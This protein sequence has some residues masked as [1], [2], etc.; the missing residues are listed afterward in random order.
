M[1]VFKLLAPL[2]LF[3]CALSAIPLR[4][5]DPVL[6]EHFQQGKVLWATQ[7]DRDGASAKFEQVLAALEPK[8]KSLEGEWLQMLCETYNWLA[9]LNDRNPTRKAR[10]PKDLEALLDLNPDFEVDRNITNAR[11]QGLFESLRTGRLVRVKLTLEPE[12][13]TLIVDGRSRMPGSL[14]KFMAPGSHK[15]TYSKPGYQSSEQQVDLAL[16][17]AKSLEL[18]LTRI[19]STVSIC[20]APANVEIFL[21]G[22]SV[23]RTEGQA[24]PE[25][26]PLAE[27]AGV[28]LAEL[29]APFVLGELPAGKHQLEFRAPCLRQRRLELDESFASPFA[30][31]VLEAVKLE[32]S[33]GLLSVSTSSP[34]GE[35]LLSGKSYGPVPVKDLQVCSGSYDLQVRFPAGGFT[36]RVELPE[37]KAVQVAA[38]P[39]ARMLYLGFEGSEEF[40]GRDRVL[41]LLTELGARLKTIAYLAPA[42]S[43]TP[44]E[45]LTRIKASKE[46]ELTLLARPVPGKPIH[47]IELVV[48]TLHGEEERSVVKPL[49]QDPLGA[50]AERLNRM[51]PLWEPWAGLNLLD[52]AG[53]PGPWVL[54]ADE[55]ASRAGIKTAKAISQVNG[56]PV[57]DVQ[58]FRKALAEATGGRISLTQDET[59][60]QLALSPQALEIPLNASNLCYPF[61]L[62]ELRLRYLGAKGDEAGLLRLNQALALMHF[63][64]YDR[65]MEVLRDARV[66]ATHGVS[67]GTLDYYTGVCLLRLGNVYVPEAIQAFN[68]ALKYPQ[69]T[70]FGPEGPL[71]APLARQALED[72]KP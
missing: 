71:I 57:A 5:Q 70:L 8:G 35:L 42:P 50:L 18:K 55:A 6:K 21:D 62:A 10:A 13:G 53:E 32:P 20:T 68:Q 49:E 44:Q 58:A 1:R 12:G 24:P 3:L 41:R 14:V 2:L 66:M 56:K 46:A 11:L 38:S 39:K 27:K 72:L 4:G 19:S 31:H 34:G 30:D 54:R 43:E 28:S 23:G 22:K 37:G 25:L 69:A 7:G 64:H 59:P 15:I 67:Q 47:E 48:S 26:R 52:L 9:V 33:R 63:R 61:V 36:Q 51:P 16:K 40:A 60:I 17:E 45:A 29:S 65:A